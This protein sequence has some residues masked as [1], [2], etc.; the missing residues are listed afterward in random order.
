MSGDRGVSGD[1]AGALLRETGITSAQQR[2]ACITLAGLALQA[3]GPEA[4]GPVLRGVLEVIGVIPYPVPPGRKQ[5]GHRQGDS[6]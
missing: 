5:F 4:A 3:A 1:R 6:T 2:A